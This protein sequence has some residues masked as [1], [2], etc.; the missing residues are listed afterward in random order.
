MFRATIAFGDEPE[1]W[2]VNRMVFIPKCYSNVK[3]YRP[4]SLSIFILKLSWRDMW[5][6]T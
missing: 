4:I 3:D 2:R 5:I 6:N 1:A